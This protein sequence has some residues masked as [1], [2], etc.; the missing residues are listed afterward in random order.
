MTKHFAKIGIIGDE[1]ILGISDLG[2]VI[3]CHKSNA[4]EGPKA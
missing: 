1:I 3:K 2:V 4:K